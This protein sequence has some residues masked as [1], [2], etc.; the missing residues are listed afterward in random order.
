LALL[1]ASGLLAL[2]A[3]LTI[4]AGPATGYAGEA[5]AQLFSP[6]HYIETVLG[7]QPEGV[8]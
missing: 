7:G 6:Q 8:R 4:F 1:P 5:A 2:L 3:L